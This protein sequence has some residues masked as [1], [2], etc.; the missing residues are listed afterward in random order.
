MA[1][2]SECGSV[3]SLDFL[4][5][6]AKARQ[7]QRSSRENQVAC[8]SYRYSNFRMRDATSEALVMQAPDASVP[9]FLMTAFVCGNKSRLQSTRVSCVHAS[10]QTGST[11]LVRV[12]G[13]VARPVN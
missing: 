6:Q 1:K 13:E 3:S 4:L 7:E 5:T 9:S 12:S 8:S 11:R 2:V 10:S